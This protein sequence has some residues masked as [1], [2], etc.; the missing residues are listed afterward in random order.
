M[1]RS[2]RALPLLTAVGAVG[3]VSVAFAADRVIT[4]D[5]TATNVSAHN[6]DVV[7]SR[8]RSDGQNRLA[9]RVFARP[10]TFA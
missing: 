2:S 5:T 1:E 3:L 8:A 6:G 9:E 4:T 7:W 10:R